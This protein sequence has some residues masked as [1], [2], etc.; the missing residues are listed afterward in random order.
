MTQRRCRLLGDEQEGFCIE[1]VP[2]QLFI[3][4]GNGIASV[5]LEVRRSQIV[6]IGCN[7]PIECSKTPK[8]GKRS[9]GR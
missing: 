9:T 6:V 1:L 4:Y 7:A 3:E 8:K 2:I 5:N